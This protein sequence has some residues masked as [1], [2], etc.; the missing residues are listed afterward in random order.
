MEKKCKV[1]SLQARSLTP[2]FCL[3]TQKYVTLNTSAVQIG[4]EKVTL[5]AML[6]IDC[7]SEVKNVATATTT[8]AVIKNEGCVRWKINSL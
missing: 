7:N 8:D 3:T 2:S 6:I 4:G 1:V 5:E